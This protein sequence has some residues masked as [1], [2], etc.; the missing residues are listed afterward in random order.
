MLHNLV[1][2]LG[3]IDQSPGYPVIFTETD[4]VVFSEFD[5]PE[6]IANRE[7]YRT[8]PLFEILAPGVVHSYLN[9]H[10]WLMPEFCSCKVI[11]QYAVSARSNYE[12]SDYGVADSVEQVVAYFHAEID[13]PDHTYLIVMTAILREHQPPDGGWRW[14][15]WG[16][17]IGTQNPKCEYLYDETD[18]DL[19]WCFHIYEV[20]AN[21]E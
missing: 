17:Y 1:W 14:H 19:V 6:T 15:K 3:R 13:D 16:P 20:E 21:N 10:Y 12:M 5:V 18:I 2:K 4:G 7:L 9:F 11:N 8:T